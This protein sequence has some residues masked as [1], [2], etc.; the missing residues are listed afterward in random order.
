MTGNSPAKTPDELIVDAMQD[1]SRAE[2]SLRA[3][4]PLHKRIVDQL[5]A[6]HFISLKGNDESEVN[7]HIKQVAAKADSEQAPQTAAPDTSTSR[8]ET[9]H[10]GPSNKEIKSLLEREHIEKIRRLLDDRSERARVYG[11]IIIVFLMANEGTKIFLKNIKQ[12]FQ[13][14]ALEIEGKTLLSRIARLRKEGAIQS[15]KESSR[16]QYRLTPDGI[17]AAKTELGYLTGAS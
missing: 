1:C 6:D 5:I 4:L 2:R 17:S 10:A 12:E 3:I 9:P 8:N 16:G 14:F 11:A 15:I 13:R 7:L